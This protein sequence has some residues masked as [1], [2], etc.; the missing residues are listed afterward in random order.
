MDYLLIL[1]AA[2]ARILPHPPNVTPVAAMA[3]FGGAYLSRRYALAY[4]LMVMAL[5]DCVLNLF[6][7]VSWF[8]PES[9]F[10]YGSFL[11]AGFFGLWC[12]SRRNIGV[13]YLVC[14]ASSIQCYL[15]TNFGTWLVSGLY[16]KNGTGLL[17]C[18]LAGVPFF[19]NSLVGDLFW[20]SLLLGAYHL[21]YRLISVRTRAI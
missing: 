5:S 8:L 12:R 13:L 7:G 3:L 9:L 15:V 14:L 1:F 4:P 20:F 19:R 16:P 21:A 18:Y 17:Q 10:V 6:F 2:I 11:I